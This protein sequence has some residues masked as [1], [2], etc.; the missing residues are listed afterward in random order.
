MTRLQWSLSL[1]G[2]NLHIKIVL[3]ENDHVVVA[4][5]SH[6]AFTLSEE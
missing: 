6:W 1:F 5:N 3:I 2:L 4:D